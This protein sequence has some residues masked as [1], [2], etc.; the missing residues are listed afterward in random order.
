MLDPFLFTST[1][2]LAT[3]SMILGD[4]AISQYYTSNPYI[5]RDLTW[6]TTKTMNIGVDF[7]M[8]KGKLGL[9]VDAHGARPHLNDNAIEIGMQI[10]NMLGQIHMDLACRSSIC[11]AKSIWIQEF[12]TQRK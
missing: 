12:R 7:E 11:W 2:A 3:N 4:R 1:Y 5:Y 10:V 6:S 8:W 9:E